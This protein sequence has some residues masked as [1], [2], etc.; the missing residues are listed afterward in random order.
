MLPRLMSFFRLWQ[1]GKR[2]LAADVIS[3]EPVYG[4][5]RFKRCLGAEKTMRNLYRFDF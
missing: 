3:P 1:S 5:E 4:F 2:S